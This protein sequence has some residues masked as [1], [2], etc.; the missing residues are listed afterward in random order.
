VKVPMDLSDPVQSFS[1]R[2]HNLRDYL[3]LGFIPDPAAAVDYVLSLT[4]SVPT[5]IQSDFPHLLS[6][7]IES[8]VERH[9]ENVVI[10]LTAGYDSRAILGASLEV[11]ANEAITCVTFGTATGPDRHAASVL[12]KKLGV[13]HLSVDPGLFSWDFDELV[14]LAKKRHA[15]TGGLPPVDGLLMFERLAVAIPR[16][17][18][19]LSG[20]L[21]D[22]LSVMCPYFL[23]HGVQPLLS[24]LNGLSDTS[25]ALKDRLWSDPAGAADLFLQRHR[26][27]LGGNEDTRLRTT[28]SDFIRE[29]GGLLSRFAGM[30]G[31]DLLE[32]AFRQPQRTRDVVTAAFKRCIT[33]FEDPRWVGYW[34]SRPIA[35]RLS[36]RAYVDGL[37]AAFPKIFPE[38]RRPSRSGSLFRRAVPQRL[39]AA[40]RQRFAPA[41]F[42]D[43]LNRG[44]P[45][46]NES[47][48]VF[49]QHCAQR[50]D[51]RRI[52]GAASA[53]DALA[54]LLKSPNWKDRD[55][56]IFAASFEVHVAAGSLPSE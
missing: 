27:L 18:P 19:V 1:G 31:Y 53:R 33:P 13:R 37:Q 3:A 35:E 15:S 41:P 43:F 8:K 16:D 24:G 38:P 54:R 49:L 7:I 34:L 40:L 28:F 4:G 25:L 56:A 5:Q 46:H 22:A 12:C 50:F 20:Y 51:A 10:P 32:L 45:R 30:T 44:D 52:D 42:A 14:D 47:K 21:G 36:D 6:R 48:R 9:T 17:A 39:R 55:I 2:Q 26:F 29:H 23:R 11:F